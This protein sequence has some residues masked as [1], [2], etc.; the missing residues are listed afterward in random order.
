MFGHAGAQSEPVPE[1]SVEDPIPVVISMFVRDDCGHCIDAKAFLAD[2]V[3]EYPHVEL[4]YLDLTVE[5]NAQLFDDVTTEYILVKGTPLTLID[6]TLIQG[7]GTAETT[8]KVF[9]DLVASASGENMTFAEALESGDAH[10]HDSF[11]LG[12]TCDS[13][14][15]CD[16]SHGEFLVTIP[17]IGKTIDVGGFSLGMMSAVLGF[18]DGFNPCAMWVLVM[19]LLILSQVG[20]R[21]RMIQYAGLFILAEAIMYY[22]ILTVWFT[23]WDFVALDRI[24]TPLVGLLA[25]GSGIYF[26]YKYYTFSPECK[27]AGA[28]QRAKITSKVKEYAAKPLTLGVA[29]GILGLAFSVNVFE[30]A[31]SIGIPQAYTKVLELNNL[32]WVGRQGY[33]GLYILMYMI[34]DLIVFGIALWSIDKIGITEKYSK[35][36]SLIG[37][38]LMLALGAILL[39]R[40]T[41]L[42]F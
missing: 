11:A 16:D 40:P 36:S 20:S 42:I 7:F 12:T 9:T 15:Y 32:S 14:E 38:I 6:G 8:G 18:I 22:L 27:V 24:V 13:S 19:F 33:M 34:D 21:K 10:V 1:L 29:L 23:V 31:C 3:V 41:L 4:N 25:V 5:E 35:W 30:F 2:F 37:G 39:I 26:L 28:D 17:V